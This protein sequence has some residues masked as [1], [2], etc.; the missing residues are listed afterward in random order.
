MMWEHPPHEL[1]RVSGCAAAANALKTT[2]N[3]LESTHYTQSLYQVLMGI[4]AKLSVP[5]PNEAMQVIIRVRHDCLLGY[6]L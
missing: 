2:K 6:R 3:E 5:F 4:L 1:G